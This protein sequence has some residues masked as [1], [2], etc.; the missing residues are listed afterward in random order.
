MKNTVRIVAL[1]MSVVMLVSLLVSCSKNGNVTDNAGTKDPE[2]SLQPGQ[3]TDGS[4]KEQQKNYVFEVVYPSVSVSSLKFELTDLKLVKYKN[5]MSEAKRMFNNK[6]T[7]EDEFK[8]TLYEL[9]S[10]EAEMEVQRGIAYIQYFYDISDSTAWN[11]YLYAYEM[12]DEAHDL[13]WDFYNVIR[14]QL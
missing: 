8:N 2:S 13:F 14:K 11:N 1:L 9:L 6:N 3:T 5:K 7:S 10:L 4:D 12:H